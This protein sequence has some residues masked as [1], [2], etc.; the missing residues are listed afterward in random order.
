MKSFSQIISQQY[1]C[2]PEN[3]ISK[4]DKKNR[5]CETFEIA[6]NSIRFLIRLLVPMILEYFLVEL[7]G[8]NFSCTFLIFEIGL[9]HEIQLF[10]LPFF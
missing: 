10:P 1:E 9:D 4:F 8:L 6:R 3:S 7:A 5:F 2:V